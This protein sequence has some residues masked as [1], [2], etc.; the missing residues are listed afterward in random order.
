MNIKKS[1]KLVTGLLLL[2][3][4][5]FIGCD[6][7]GD[8]GD[9][10]VNPNESTYASTG[11]LI[12]TVQLRLGANNFGTTTSST[13]IPAAE[14]LSGLLCQYF[15]EPTYPQASM[16]SA[17]SLNISTT[18]PYVGVLYDL[19]K[20]IDRNMDET[21]KVEAAKSGSNASQIAIARIMK[22]YIYWVVTDKWGNVPY[23]EALQSPDIFTPK[24]D[25]QEAIYTDLLKELKEAQAQFDGGFA[26]SSDL[27]YNGDESKWK[28]FANSLRMLIALRMSKVYPTPSGLAAQEFSAAFNDPAGYIESNEDG[29]KLDYP[30]NANPYNNPYYAPFNSADNG[31]SETYTK[32]MSGLGDTRISAHATNTTGVPYGSKSPAATGVDWARILS[33]EFKQTEGTVHFINAASVLLAA[34]EACQLGWVSG[35]AKDLYEKGVETSFDQW[36]VDIPANYLTTGSANFTTGSGVN[37]I[38]GELVPGSTAKT[39]NP[40][41]RIQLQ[42]YIAFYPDGHQGWSNWRRTGV[43]GLKPTTDA[44]NSSKEISRRFTYGTTDYS[45]NEIQVKA[46]AAAMGGDND[47]VRMWW[48]K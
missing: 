2:S 21:E 48:D 4:I 34:A 25:E 28:K 41:Q 22:A 8:F 14:I 37:D 11:T 38:S 18:A 10:N 43:P 17:A 30:G 3:V 35:S 33:S 23:S 26:V 46:A 7:L 31:V 27:I 20:V 1:T 24:Y 16:Y 42:Q 9:K 5:G 29:F 19:K 36:G 6:K 44:L 32:L 12:S 13:A 15:S 47:A 40:L 39:N 45:T